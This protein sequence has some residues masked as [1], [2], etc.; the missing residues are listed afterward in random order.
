MVVASGF[1]SF[2][3]YKAYVVSPWLHCQTF[4]GEAT[5]WKGKNMDFG[6]CATDLLGDLSP[7]FNLS[8]PQLFTVN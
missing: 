8:R 3:S 2:V 5:S 4:L 7:L 6:G 1:H